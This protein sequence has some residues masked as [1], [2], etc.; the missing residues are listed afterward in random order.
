MSGEA[1]TEPT[2]R[3]LS[4]RQADTVRRLT[5]AA[6]EEVRATGFDG[7]TVRN[8]ARRAGVAP[9]T[10]YTY[11]TSKNHL[12]TEVFWRR[13]RALPPIPQAPQAPRER[14]IAVLREIA[15]LVSDEP[16]LAAAC[17]TALLG[18]DPDVRELRLRIGR[19]IHRRLLAALD[20]G[21][22]RPSPEQARVLNALE[23]AYAGALVHAG[24]GYS[25]YAEMA[26][27][28]AE[29]AGLLF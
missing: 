24:M 14:V 22:E 13:L 8:V 25:S 3:R 21:A 12:I 29:V 26:D 18:T 20:P 15:L 27:R 1:M 5:D 6:V 10:A 11:F 23:F 4:G 7:F 9:A 17:T 2:R 19:T 16:E 28:L